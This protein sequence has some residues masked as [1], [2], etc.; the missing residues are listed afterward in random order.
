MGQDAR[1]AVWR[2]DGR[3]GTEGGGRCELTVRLDGDGEFPWAARRRRVIGG[4][5]GGREEVGSRL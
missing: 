3:V 5:E 4:W 2:V 1:S